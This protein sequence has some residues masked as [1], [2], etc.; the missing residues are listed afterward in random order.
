MKPP[1]DKPFIALQKFARLLGW[2]PLRVYQHTI[3]DD[4]TTTYSY[5]VT[6]YESGD[7]GN[8]RTDCFLQFNESPIGQTTKY[9]GAVYAIRYRLCTGWHDFTLHR[10]E[11]RLVAEAARLERWLSREWFNS[12]EGRT[13]FR[14]LHPECTGFSWKKIREVGPPSAS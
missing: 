9:Q 1:G 4:P 6:W 2:S 11:R 13:Q 12:Y 10:N 14:Q 3:T 8:P 7:S 5:V